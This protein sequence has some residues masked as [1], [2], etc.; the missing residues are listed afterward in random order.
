[1]FD[2]DESAADVISDTNDPTQTDPV[3]L[4]LMDAHSF[5]RQAINIARLVIILFFSIFL[6]FLFLFPYF[7]THI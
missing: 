7:P 1:M 6:L 4:D 3:D 2:G 5:R